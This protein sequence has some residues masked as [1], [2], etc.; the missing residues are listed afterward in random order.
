MSKV[1]NKLTLLI[2]GAMLLTAAAA[3]SII[4]GLEPLGTSANEII[5]SP[6]TPTVTATTTAEPTATAQPQPVA[7]AASPTP[8]PVPTATTAAPTD[9]PPPSEATTVLP[10]VIEYIVQPGDLLF[11]L[12]QR[13]NTT[14]D[15]LITLNPDIDP[16]S[17]IVGTRLRVPN[18][19]VDAPQP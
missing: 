19:E 10:A 18:P 14:N 16:E 2:G 9:T 8:R 17:L 12:S 15:V 11:G 7:S 6:A 1:F 13:F 4:G 3:G 5:W